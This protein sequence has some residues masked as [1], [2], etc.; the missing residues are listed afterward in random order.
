MKKILSAAFYLLLIST[1][2]FAN[3]VA[4]SQDKDTGSIIG[5]NGTFRFSCS[6]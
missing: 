3:G 4:D 2:L 1:V 5:N 6:L